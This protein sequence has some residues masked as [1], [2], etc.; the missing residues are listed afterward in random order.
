MTFN[1]LTPYLSVKNAAAAID[2]Y[3]AAFG[4]IEHGE[5]Y[6]EADGHIGH[7]ELRFGALPLFISDEY[8]ALDVFGPET[9]G[10][11][12]S[13]LVLQCA[14][15]DAL[16]QRA[17]DAGARIDRPISDTGHGRMGWLHDPFG[18]RWCISGSGEQGTGSGA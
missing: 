3:A 10:G 15:P 14:D 7:A 4:A 11:A 12:T 8:P 2:F 18:H 13:S 5:R 17:I 1:S 9:R 16:F 6:V